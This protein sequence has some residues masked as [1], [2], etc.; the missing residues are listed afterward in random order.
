MGGMGQ[1]HILK[2]Q[3]YVSR[4][5]DTEELQKAA[6]K[7]IQ[8]RTPGIHNSVHLDVMLDGVCRHRLTGQG[9]NRSLQRVNSA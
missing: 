4:E 1:L 8:L 9:C 3:K 5:K 7:P 2:L 6:N